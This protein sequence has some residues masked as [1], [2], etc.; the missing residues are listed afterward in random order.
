MP[1]VLD[2]DSIS[3]CTRVRAHHLV[4]DPPAREGVVCAAPLLF[5]THP[6]ERLAW[7]AMSAETAPQLIAAADSASI[8]ASTLATK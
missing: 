5:A 4:R 3:G 2:S 8:G 6:R 7:P 1:I